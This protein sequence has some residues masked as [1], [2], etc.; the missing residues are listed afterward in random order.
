MGLADK[1]RVSE[2]RHG[3]TRATGGRRKA[4]SYRRMIC[5]TI[6]PFRA[7]PVHASHDT[8][9]RAM[10]VVRPGRRQRHSPSGTGVNAIEFAVP[11]WLRQHGVLDADQ[12]RAA[13][14]DPRWFGVPRPDRMPTPLAGNLLVIVDSTGTN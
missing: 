1:R 4:A 7:R 9:R 10:R 8:L 13:R 6:R 12:E 2:P 5:G 11:D 3:H 14:T